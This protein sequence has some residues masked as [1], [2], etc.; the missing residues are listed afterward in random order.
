MARAGSDTLDNT[1]PAAGGGG[2]DQFWKGLIEP[3]GSSLLITL[4]VASAIL[5][6]FFTLLVP[7]MVRDLDPGY[8]ATSGTDHDVFTTAKLLNL[9][10]SE[11]RNLLVAIIGASVTRSSFGTEE[12][13]ETAFTDRYG[14]AVDVENLSTSRQSLWEHLAIL[15]MIAGRRPTIAIVGIGPIRFTADEA[16]MREIIENPRLG[17]RLPGLDEQAAAMGIEPPRS[18]GL[19][20]ADNWGFV[21]ARLDSLAVNLR[22]GPLRQKEQPYLGRE[23]KDQDEFNEHSRLVA[24]RLDRFDANFDNNLAVLDTM[25]QEFGSREN[26]QLVFVEHPVNPDFVDQFMGRGDYEDYLKQMQRWS[27]ANGAH[28]WRIALDQ[29]IGREDYFDWAHIRTATAKARMR[30]DLIGRLE[31]LLS[32]L[33]VFG[34]EKQE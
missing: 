17:I 10:A 28:Y 32:E 34:E 18:T 33:E 23:K 15:R 31:P 11:E 19:Y 26:L 14:I 5:I 27:T 7:V 13:I 16:R 8:W 29:E 24:A 21:I 20:A 22:R 6:V 1:G 25:Q 4:A 3:S 12:Q 30:D 2:W 9:C